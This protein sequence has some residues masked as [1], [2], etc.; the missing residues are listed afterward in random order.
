MRMEVAMDIAH[1]RI[2]FSD[3][4]WGTLELLGCLGMILFEAT[5]LALVT[6]KW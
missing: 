1:Q 3:L 4:M 2:E 5:L 6:G